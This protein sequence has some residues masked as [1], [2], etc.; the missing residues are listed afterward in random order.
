[1]KITLTRYE[2]EQYFNRRGSLHVLKEHTP[3]NPYNFVEIDVPK[4]DVPETSGNVLL[5]RKS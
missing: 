1:M 5:I 3:N 2:R 4:E